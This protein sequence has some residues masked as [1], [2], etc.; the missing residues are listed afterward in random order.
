MQ[1]DKKYK[2][3]NAVIMAAGMSTRLAP[4][5]Y[6]T[7][8]A[9]LNVHGEVLIERQI[10]QLREAGIE[11]IFVVTGYKKE[12]FSYLEEKFKVTLV[13]NPYYETRNNHSSLYVVRE[14]LKNT[15]ICC[16]DNYFPENVFRSEEEDSYYATVFE[17]GETDEWCVF[18]DENG[19]IREVE[20][21]GCDQW[22]MKGHAFLAEP[23]TAKLCAYLEEAMR[24]EASENLFWEDLFILHRQELVLYQKKF[25]DQK[26]CEFDSLEELR[27][28]DPKYLDQ[29]GSAIMENL[30]DI[31]QCTEGEIR[32]I[33]PLKQGNQ[34]V[35]IEFDCRG[36]K[37]RYEYAK[38]QIGR[39]ET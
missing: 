21:G 38:K 3:D 8:K 9:L 18:A 30:A 34:V 6:E 10:R 11:E 17:A 5:S 35:G 37:Y 36:V 28:F 19:R 25:E 7:P 29:T 15:Y 16:G 1:N 27:A 23:F 14:H 33:Y 2:V 24:K 12:C 39:Y 20:I 13:E 31:L 22:V 4:L 26:I 32:Q